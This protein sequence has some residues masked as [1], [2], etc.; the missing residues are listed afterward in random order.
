MGKYE[1]LTK[2]G[3]KPFKSVKISAKDAGLKISFNNN[4]TITVTENTKIN[5]GNG[6]IYAKELK[7][8]EYNIINIERVYNEKFYDI[9]EVTDTNSFIV[10]N[11]FDVHNCAFI[12]NYDDFS[13]SIIPTISS[14]KTSKIIMS[15]TPK[16][17]NH[18]YDLWKQAENGQSA[19][20]NF[21]VE[22][23]EIPGRDENWKEEQI[24]TLKGGKR[25][26]AQEYACEFLG[27]AETLIDISVL[28]SLKYKSPIEIK[29]N[30]KYY[31][32]P[33]ENHNYILVGDGA[34][35][36]G[37]KFAIHIIDVT[38]IPFKQVVTAN[39]DEVY[40]QLPVILNSLLQQY[41]NALL[42][43]EN[44][45][46]A[47]TS[48]CDILFQV[49]EYENIFQ[50][51]RKNY[52]GVRTTLGNRPKILSTMKWV[53]E[54]K[55]IEIFDKETINQL[56]TFVN[57]NGKYQAQQGKNDD[58]VMSLAL[59]FNIFDNVK[60]LTDYDTFVKDMTEKEETKEKEDNEFL[61]L[62]S[63]SFFDDGTINTNI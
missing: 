50:Q 21:K 39:F 49:Y 20:K 41:N 12:N 3:F 54:N 6:Y 10:N 34:K 32:K 1:I 63:L 56:F 48:I 52:F 40:L 2:E 35:G 60:A 29:G 38:T 18:W 17:L 25:A 23:W 26:F 22:W 61:G 14:S 59:L 9:V 28:T 36:G 43:I 11:N 27:S 33:I 62:L 4:T 46:G 37:D 57:H 45:E 42:L 19:F 13:N 16:G 58:L 7:I 5:L 44:N 15:S 8:G 55:K 30:I 47:G 24:K 53:I 31:E 51:E